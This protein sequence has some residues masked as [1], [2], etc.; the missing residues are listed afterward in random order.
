MRSFI[1]ISGVSLLVLSSNVFA[2]VDMG[3]ISYSALASADGV[4]IPIL[5]FWALTIL[6]A[7]MAL[8]ARLPCDVTKCGRKACLR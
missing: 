8:L 4:D 7:V 1:K 5:P 2:Q 6:G 3:S